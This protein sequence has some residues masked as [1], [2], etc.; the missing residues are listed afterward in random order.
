VRIRN[1]SRLA[2]AA[3][4][5]AALLLFYES[6][7]QHQLSIGALKLH[8]H[9]LAAAY[10][11]RP[12]LVVGLF[13]ATFV[14]LTAL[15]IP[16]SVLLMTVAAGAIFGF[17]VGIFVDSFAAAIGCT[18]AFLCSRYLL[19]DWVAQRYGRAIERFGTDV[20]SGSYLLSLRLI[21]AVPYF[22]VNVGMALTRIRVS[23]FYIASQLGMLPAMMLYVN[24]G[25]ELGA[26]SDMRE[27]V[28][29]RVLCALALLA[30]LPMVS[31]AAAKRMRIARSETASI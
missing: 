29:L 28:S 8:R 27:I 12:L 25:R 22:L 15:S 3:L 10:A 11:H 14:T 9:E 18:V 23:R 20:E 19:R 24:A 16:G 30:M 7:F 2:I 6:G 21:P 26:M 5:V 13:F 4:F 17:W 31:G 1:Y